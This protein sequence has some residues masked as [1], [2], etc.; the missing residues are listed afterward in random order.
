MRIALCH[1]WLTTYGGSDQV[2]SEL[3]RIFDVRDVYTFAAEP[4][5]AAELFPDS[6][7]KVAHR[8]GETRLAR[9]H[10]GWLL[11]VM[12][13]AWRRLDLSGYDLV[14]TSSHSCV[15]AIRVPHGTPV[16]SY[17]HTPMRY[18]WEWRTELGRFPLPLRAVWPGIAARF[19][20]ADRRWAARVT[21]FVA[22]SNHVADRIGRYYGRDAEVVHPPID[23]DFWSPDPAVE[24]E[25]FY[26]YA[27]RLVA[28]KRPDLAIQAA[29]AAGVRLVVAGAGPE[30]KRLRS[31]AGPTVEFVGSPS[32]EAL[33]DLYRR[34]RALVFPGV[35]D[36]GMTMAEAQSCG[37]PVIARAQGGALE[38]VVDAVTGRLY[39]DA[40]VEGLVVELRSFDP[41]RYPSEAIRS[42]G[43][44]FARQVFSERMR[45]LVR[46]SHR[47]RSPQQ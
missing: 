16:I 37:T 25:D 35:E 33:R 6:E 9:E 1:E 2:A 26:L 5:L 24:R 45:E 43:L 39:P 34:T 8:I 38:I 15:N 30:A 28:Y 46:P 13:Y 36:F 41:A 4:A 20:A 32:S 22:N 31:M 10:W 19:R 23:T 11:P 27:G 42:N 47:E 12:P 29:S 3:A 7:V 40:S 21:T 14:I 17:C 18:A 44:R